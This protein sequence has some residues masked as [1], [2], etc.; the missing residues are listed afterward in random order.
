MDWLREAPE[1]LSR[2]QLSL[3]MVEGFTL[4]ETFR[5]NERVKKWTIRFQGSLPELDA[6]NPL[7]T[8]DWYL[9]VDQAYPLG[10]IGI[11]PAKANGI[12][13]TYP[14]QSY[15]AE[16][17]TDL[18]WRTGNICANTQAK[19]IGRH[20]YDVEPYTTEDRLLWH[21]QRAIEWIRCASRGELVLP[22][23]PFEFPRTPPSRESS[24]KVRF[25]EGAIAT[26]PWSDTPMAS[27]HA[28][29]FN[30]KTNEKTWFVELLMGPKNGEL[31]QP[32]WGQYITRH[33]GKSWDGAWIRLQ[34]IPTVKPYRFPE[35]WGE[36]RQALSEQGESL[37]SIL[38]SI[39]KC[40]RDGEIHF[41]LLGFP[42]P[43]VL[44]GPPVITHWISLALPDLSSGKAY[45]NGFR[46][47][48]K[49]YFE[50]DM[51]TRFRSDEK[52]V[53]MPTENWHSD[54]IQNRGRFQEGLRSTRVAMIGCG[55]LGAP[56]AEMLIRGGVH[57][58]TIIDGEKIEIGNLSRHTLSMNDIGEGKADRL[59]ERLNALNPHAEV[60]F[61]SSKITF[62]EE[63]TFQHF[64]E[65]DIIIDCTANDELLHVLSGISFPH[66][67]HFFSISIGFRAKRMFCFHAKG[68]S[69]PVDE[70]ISEMSEWIEAE[71]DEFKGET[72]PREGIGCYHPVFPAQCNDMWLW[73]S[74][75]VKAIA[76]GVDSLPSDSILHVYEQNEDGS[77]SVNRAVEEPSYE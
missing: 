15:N 31:V 50:N 70:Y 10:L 68:E 55:A 35:T 27:G 48:E 34:A 5:W 8:T 58:M 16:G 29:V 69:F 19:I 75:A 61:V 6:G 2:A 20:G 39:T 33:R 9:T 49:G 53:Y 66:D 42:I 60:A 21:C 1:P 11:Y 24:E 59:A 62:T 40:L 37:R 45:A 13:G 28:R 63:E 3:E 72:F 26:S 64:L 67:V 41:L 38:G 22:G 7:R 4:M 46:A 32:L 18:P 36:L 51:L 14:H 25:S 23:E 71:Q 12:T 57:Q 74:I 17:N 73:A 30:L 77:V 54:Q 65:H 44:E 47:N 56:I 43:E 52:L 76:K